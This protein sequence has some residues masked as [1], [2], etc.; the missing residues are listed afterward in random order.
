[1]KEKKDPKK[2]ERKGKDLPLSPNTK[3]KEKLKKVEKV[4]A[5]GWVV[6]KAKLNFK[7]LPNWLFSKL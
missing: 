4:V 6:G 7:D 1:M 2:K 3:K 5:S